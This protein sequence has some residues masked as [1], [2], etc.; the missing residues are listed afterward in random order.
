MSLG[1]AKPVLL[2][3]PGMLNTARIW[4]RVVPLLQGDAEIRIADVTRQATW[5][6]TRGHSWLTYPKPGAWWSADS[7]W[8][9]ML[10]WK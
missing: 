4:D 10:H 3:I 2:L 9:A 7:R 1:A 5:R 6:A 8:V